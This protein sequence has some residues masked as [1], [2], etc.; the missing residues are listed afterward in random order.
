[1]RGIYV[2][3]K[4]EIR[5]RFKETMLRTRYYCIGIIRCDVRLGT[6]FSRK[7]RQVVSAS[8]ATGGNQGLET[9]CSDCKYSHYVGDFG[10]RILWRVLH[11]Y[12]HEYLGFT[13]RIMPMSAAVLRGCF[14]LLTID[15]MHQVFDTA[16][17]RSSSI[18]SCY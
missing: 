18:A 4:W 15:N 8:T 7:T 6:I 5:T 10:C 12:Q 1:M 11:V 14:V 13:L 16:H 9:A 17:T 2:L 3:K